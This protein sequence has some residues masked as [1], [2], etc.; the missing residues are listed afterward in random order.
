MRAHQIDNVKKWRISFSLKLYYEF[1]N[2]PMVKNTHFYMSICTYNF[3]I[4]LTI[5]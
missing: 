1:G 4:K 2:K 5:Y 3:T